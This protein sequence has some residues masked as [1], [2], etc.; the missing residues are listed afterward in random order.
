[1]GVEVSM[2]LLPGLVISFMPRPQEVGAGMPAPYPADPGPGLTETRSMGIAF[3]AA[4][5]LRAEK[6]I[7][8]D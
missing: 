7:Y 1:M 2:R 8:L 6:R 4:G 5:Q 3:S